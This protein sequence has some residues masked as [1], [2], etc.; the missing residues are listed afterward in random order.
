MG[1]ELKYAGYDGIIIEG[2]AEKPVYL[3]INDD[4]VE[5]RSAEHLW[6]KDVNE[7]TDT[8]RNETDFDARV[9]CI[10]PAGENLVKFACVVNDYTRAAGRSGVGA[11][12]G[13]KT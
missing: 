6:G 9:A 2:K 10:G 1:P 3:W 5:I 11:V 7:T 13:S 8:L 4:Q 12:M